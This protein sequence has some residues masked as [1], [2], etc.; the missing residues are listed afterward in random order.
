MGIQKRWA[1]FPGE[2]TLSTCPDLHS[3][4]KCCSS[5]RDPRPTQTWE[6]ILDPTLLKRASKRKAFKPMGANWPD[7]IWNLLT[8]MGPGWSLSQNWNIWNTLIN[9]QLS[10]I[11]QRHSLICRDREWR[12]WGVIWFVCYSLSHALI[13]I[14]SK[15]SLVW[16]PVQELAFS[17]S[18]LRPCY[19]C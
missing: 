7:R 14:N 9:K 15:F 12:N 6:T 3:I 2:K 11:L 16:A 5:S 19:T 17:P 4:R 10:F 1:C 18:D 8:W 13:P